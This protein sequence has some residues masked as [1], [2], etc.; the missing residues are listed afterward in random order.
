MKPRD[1][2]KLL[3]DLSTQYCQ[4]APRSAALNQSALQVL[5]DGGSHSKRLIKPFPPRI[6]TAQGAYITD[7]DN[8]QILDFWQGHYTNL[9]GY[10]P[11]V[12]THVLKQALDEGAFLQTGFTDKYQVELA[13]LL[14]RQTNTEK[15]RF[16]T[17]GTL[18]TMYAILLANAY[19]GRELVLKV[20]GGWHGAHLWGLKGVGYQVGFHQ[21]DSSGVPDRLAEK[22]I[23][24]SFNRTQMLVNEFKKYGSQLACFILEPVIGAG[25]LMPASQE[26]MQ[27]AR[28]LTH[29]Y[30]VVLILDEV[31]SGFRFRA[32][33]AGALYNVQP[34]LI[35][36][37]KIIG[38]GMPVAAV[39]GRADIMNLVS[40]E[41]GK[42]VKFYGGTYSGHPGSM[43]AST[44]LLRYLVANEQ[45]IYPQL[46]QI[47]RQTRQAV[48]NVF[49]EEDVP[50]FFSGGENSIIPDNSL[51][52][53]LFPYD[54]NCPLDS[55]DDIKDPQKFD[56]G[57]TEK[58]L[59]LAMLLE[60]VHVVHGLGAN[61]LAHTSEDIQRLCAAYRKAIQ[62][63]KPYL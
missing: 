49:K 48:L 8:N 54:E 34:D 47:A 25:G 5:V 41:K 40:Q 61:A 15:V 43:L 26:Y 22:T 6:A 7:E 42:A 23:V 27:T 12:V 13:K 44:T 4:H 2:S 56:L 16:T 59:Q 24:T 45:E 11:S 51:H 60:D 35:T 33:D 31:I 50:A 32:G 14:C 21:V 55:P 58:V 62:R 46:A 37:G 28:E 36:L 30:G 17:S 19:T 1:H 3:A 20:G 52:M 63:I 18:A 9:L 57:L 39:A 38:G 29:Q 10:N 53:L